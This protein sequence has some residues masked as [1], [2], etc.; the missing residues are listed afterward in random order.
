MISI[1]QS[2]DVYRLSFR[3]DPI[4]ISIIKEV[5]TRKY[6]PDTKTWTI[7]KQYLGW[8]LRELDSS[9]YRTMYQVTSEEELNQNYA[10]DT[11]VT[12]PDEDISDVVYRVK[13]G[14]KPFQHQLDFMKFALH[15]QRAGNLRGFILADDQGLAKTCSAINLA[16]Y[17]RD[18]YGWKH[19]LIV[20]CV[21]S[22]KYTWLD[23]IELHTQGAEHGYI[24]G[25]RYRRNGSIN[26]VGSS[27][28]KLH[29]LQ[30]GTMFK[31]E[32]LLPYF[33]ITNIETLRYKVK[34]KYSITAQ[35]I[36]NIQAGDIGMICL[37][38]IHKNTH[39][40]SIQGRQLLNLYKHSGDM[41]MFLPMTG[42]PIVKKP[43]DAFLPL[44]LIGVLGKTNFSTWCSNFCI[45]GAFNDIIGYKN[46]KHLKNMLQN[47]MLRRLKSDVLDLPPKLQHVI[48][49]ENSPYQVKL[50]RKV[51]ADIRSRK[52]EIMESNNPLVE[53]LKLRQVNGSPELVDD[54][55]IVDKFY[56]S[57]VS[58]LGTL[59]ELLAEIH[60]RG[61]KVIIFSNWVKPL[62]TIYR[63]VATEYDT[64]AFTGTMSDCDRESAKHRFM[65]DANCTVMLGTVGAMGVS[66]TLTAASNV[67]FYDECWNPSDKVQAEDR[68]YRIGTSK[69]LNVYTLIAK[70]TVDDAVHKILYTKAAISKY[71]VDNDLKIKEDPVLF[72]ILAG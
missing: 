48:Y 62:R 67:I 70:D 29:D 42:T 3:Y 54:T 72:D 38:E 44:K 50:Y 25:S 20:C 45:Y 22:A 46:I 55:C 66:H 31:S 47:N 43:T 5:P 64:V 68:A 40:G 37:D 33:I 49:V 14:A 26:Y 11:T 41:C 63:F 35:L 6:E 59:L 17:N 65:H 9:P 52:A 53:F 23:E 28:D 16:L 60:N 71:I 2:G 19:C 18:R 30:T 27:A 15:R 1:V 12:I 21:N 13:E 58:K 57:K 56:P 61:E 4:L 8:L 39:P 69:T 24:L 36:A 32:E 34:G 7:S 51:Q 10:I